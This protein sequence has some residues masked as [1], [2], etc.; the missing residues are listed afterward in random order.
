MENPANSSPFD[1]DISTSPERY[2][3][4]QVAFLESSA[5]A[6]RALELATESP[7]GEVLTIEDFIGGIA[8]E[9]TVDSGV[10]TVTAT[11][12]E[13]ETAILMAN[14][15]VA[16]YQELKQTEAERILDSAI[17][18][19]DASIQSVDGE[20]EAITAEI[21]ALREPGGED[22]DVNS[23]IQR[24]MGQLLDLIA[25]DGDVT[26]LEP[27]L[28]RL[29]T[30]QL[31]QSLGG[32]DP[33]LTSLTESRAQALERRSELALTREQ[34]RVET[35]L[36]STGV[37]LMSPARDADQA[38]SLSRALVIGVLL[39]AAVGVAVAFALA[40][41]SRR[42]Q[43]RDEPELLLHAPLLAEIPSFSDQRANMP[44]RDARHSAAAEAFR[45]AEAAI[46][47][48]NG[49]ARN[50]GVVAMVAAGSGDGASVVTANLA[51]T[52]AARGG[53]VLAIDCDFGSQDLVRLLGGPDHYPGITDVVAGEVDLA[54]AV[55]TIEVAPNTGV[56]LLGRG[57]QNVTATTFFRSA[58]TE[59][60]FDDLRHHYDL[61]IVDV[62]SPLEVAYA[63][64]VLR[65]CSTVMV[66]P[67]QGDLS[68]VV[69]AMDR[70]ALSGAT[71]EGYI[72]NRS[73][74]S[75]RH[76]PFD[77]AS[78]AEDLADRPRAR[79]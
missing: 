12:D 72:Y 24:V 56:D 37:S 34:L 49:G 54:E 32:D 4:D 59:H 43:H 23:Q 16:A 68:V 27:L 41:R 35:A 75:T 61:V 38:I 77:E 22:N 48:I 33:I 53:R 14:S 70:L 50:P 62:P 69:E 26:Q 25:A 74:V 5:T 51:V 6:E 67:D 8:V 15:V 30:L 3:S 2:T 76:S 17:E 18:Q 31:V 9:S 79:S 29:Q 63:G 39:G 7:A 60:F 13:P 47:G 55:S 21:L 57:L 1:R 58:S 66:I 36:A 42:F 78:A 40:S 46:R 19:L 20:L 73:P 28:T 71:V 52:T 65:L 45:V 10:I 11:A 44:A 64:S